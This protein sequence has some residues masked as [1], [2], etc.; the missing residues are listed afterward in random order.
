MPECLCPICKTSFAA[1]SAAF[2]KLYRCDS[3]GSEYMLD[4]EH[5]ARYELPTAIHIQFRDRQGE[6]FTKF[7]FSVIIDYGYRLPPLRPN[8]QGQLLITKKMFLGAERDEILTGIMDHKGD[9][10]LSRFIR[11][12]VPGLREALELSKARSSS[13]W[14]ILDFEKELW[15]DMPSLI[16]AYIPSQDV[17]PMESTV[18]LAQ[19]S[20]L[21]SLELVVDEP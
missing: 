10:A 12:R 20:D 9:Y 3:C 16:A 17:V 11:I 18:D 8:G 15:G 6:P 13:P 21:V 4:V 5:L 7:P 1:P 2:G 14:P 19:H